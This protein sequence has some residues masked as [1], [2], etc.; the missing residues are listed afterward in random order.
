[1][2]RYRFSPEQQALLEQV[3]TPYAIY[4]FVDKRVVTLVLSDGF[5]DLFAY[6]DR[7]QAYHDMDNDMYKGTHPDDVARVAEAAV[8]F[9]TEGGSYDVV[10]RTMTKS[11]D[12]YHMIHARGEHRLTG[13]GARLAHVWYMDEGK[14]SDEAGRTGLTAALNDALR[15]ESLLRASQYDYLTGLPSMTHFFELAEAG[16]DAILA[17]GGHPALLFLDLS[18][19]KFFNT[20]YSFAEG[21][22]LIRA[23]GKTLS[24]AFGA[25]CCC[26]IGGDHFAAFT[27]EEGLEETLRKLF[28]DC[29]H[30]NDGKNLPVRVGIYPDRLES[31]RVSTA[32][33]RAKFACDNLRNTFASG[34][35][36]YNKDLRDDLVKR[37]YIL[38]N[39]DRALAE[40]WIKVCY[41]PIVRAVNG[42]VCDEEALSR[43]L[44]PEKGLIS[45]GEF[46]PVLEDAGVI[47][48]LDLYVLDRVLE[49]MARMKEAGLNVVPHSINLSRSDFT[50]CDI[51]EEIRQRVDGAGVPREQITIEITES[52]IGSD[53][54]FMREQVLRFQ[55]LGFPVWM[56]DFGSGY[57]ALDMLQSIPFDLIKF[58]MSFLRRLDEGPSPKILLTELMKLSTALGVDTVCEGVETEEQV[59]FLQEIGCSKLQGY[60]YAPPISLDR[61]LERY[62]TGTAIGFENPAE[63][64]YYEAVGRVNLHDLAV[65]AYG[66]DDG[67]DELQNFFNTLPMGII[68]L[69]GSSLRL[70]RSNQSYREFVSRFYGGDSAAG[71]SLGGIPADFGAATRSAV[72]Q[73]CRTGHRM[74]FDEEMPDGSM[75]HAFARR[76][77]VNPV[78]GKTAVAIAVLSITDPDQGTTYAGI[79][80]ALASDYY[81]LY[82]VD[83]D[84][85]RYIEY[86]S[87]VGG[88][89]LA[90][91]RHGEGFFSSARE[92]A[93][94]RIYQEDQRGF[95]V[96]FTKENILRTLDV[97]GTFTVTYRI[98]DSGA[99]IYVNMKIMRMQGKGRHLIIG[100]RAVD[101]QMK[102][103]EEY[104]ALRREE[105]AYARVMALAGDYLVLYTVDPRT[106]QYIEVRSTGAVRELDL[107][108]KGEDFFA[109]AAINGAK[110]VSPEDLPLYHREFTREKV[111][112]AVKERGSF[113]LQY[114]L[115]V[116]GTPQPVSLKVVPI[117]EADGEKLVVGVRVWSERR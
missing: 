71:S 108:K 107:A 69:Q 105:A 77:G 22:R 56:D 18:G 35:N 13:D 117:R 10:Y 46:I 54:T 57:S 94:R 68:E 47:Y 49:K 40:G 100:I 74:F 113:Q 34:F 96:T 64:G 2:E 39:L 112:A 88:M 50:A 12:G 32:C 90:V 67:D 20:R 58:D 1:M 6:T 65:L 87:P 61:I 28:A 5:C 19:M 86:S 42:R 109:Q 38:G 82:Y 9:A 21:D 93:L 11:R 80:R 83:L 85:E 24:A 43:W 84:T 16:R 15:E 79:A 110:I 102:R 51:V 59:R 98:M 60:Y 111:L 29:E 36:Y 41:Q 62:A 37:Q 91:E 81:N 52:V 26:H 115:M 70:V 103:Q 48:K 33:D 99:P 14:Y 75:V 31:V 114:H 4:Q 25:D 116:D 63:S 76:V 78:S 30:I 27:R 44:D 73:C 23:F 53:V 17:R 45:P 8:R 106:E 104:Y 7:A 55:A 89:E 101:N 3:Q 72:R 66:D 95:L 97:Q 92:E